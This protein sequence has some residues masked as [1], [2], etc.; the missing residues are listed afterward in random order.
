MVRTF[1]KHNHPPVR[2]NRV[3]RGVLERA[4]VA[5]GEMAT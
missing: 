2:P 3:T 4:E 1:G 5:G